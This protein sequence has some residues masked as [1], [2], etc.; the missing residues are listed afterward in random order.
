[1]TISGC[2]PC[3]PLLNHLLILVGAKLKVTSDTSGSNYE[4]HLPRSLGNLK[5]LPNSTTVELE[6]NFLL[7]RFQLIGPNGELVK[8]LGRHFGDT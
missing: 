2:E 7:P 6:F 8:L 1:M 5:N 4:D 3:V